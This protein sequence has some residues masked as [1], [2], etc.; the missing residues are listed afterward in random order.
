MEPIRGEWMLE[1]GEDKS[2]LCQ[3]VEQSHSLNSIKLNTFCLE[4]SASKI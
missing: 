3:K 4:K 1:E 2:F